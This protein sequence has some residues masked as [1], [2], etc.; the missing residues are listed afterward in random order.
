MNPIITLFSFAALISIL[1]FFIAFIITSILETRY[2]P[3]FRIL[4]LLPFT[5][6][7]AALILIQF[8]FRVYILTVILA[9]MFFG[10][11]IFFILPIG[12]DQKIKIVGNQDK[13]DER[14]ALFHRFYRIKPGTKEFKAYYEMRP[15][16][17]KPDDEIRKLPGL[18]EPGSMSY[19][20]FT[21]PFQQAE[22]DI[23][24]TFNKDVDFWPEPENINKVEASPEEFTMIIKGFARYLGAKLVGMTKLNQAY[25]YSHIGRSPGTWGEEIKIDHPSAIVVAVEMDFDMVRFAPHHI[26][27]TE[28]ALKY[29]EAGKIAAIIARYI[30][31][32]GYKA[33]AHIDGNYRVMCVPIAVDAG[34]GE[35]G[36]LGL[37]ITPKFGPRVRLAVITTDIPL[38]YDKPISFGV[39]DFCTFCKKCA[40]NCPSGSIDKG[41]KKVYRGTEKWI[42]NQT[43]CYKFWR[44]QGSDCSVC[45]NVCPFSHPNSF[46]HNIVRWGIKRNKLFRRFALMADDF[47]YGRRPK[48]QAKFPEW[49]KPR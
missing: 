9:V 2:R 25:V 48:N 32:I 38:V 49:H 40:T 39:Q 17:R 7:Y 8:P 20:K 33:R 37:L 30:Q 21:S 29:F 47:L 41:N 24:D 12:T 46:L 1:V 35:L 44:M 28:T 31:L 15:E 42:S 5:A 13:V 14:D 11:M 19:N 34:I 16:N 26:V 18:N 3:V 27:T 22:F 43:T 6:I 4:M 23:I 45:V 36:R 10:I